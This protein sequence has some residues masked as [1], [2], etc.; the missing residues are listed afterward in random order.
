MNLSS[1]VTFDSTRAGS[2]YTEPR[3]LAVT[4]LR[5]SRTP[6]RFQNRTHKSS[7]RVLVPFSVPP[8]RQ[9]PSSLPSAATTDL[10]FFLEPSSTRA[11]TRAVAARGG[12]GGGSFLPSVR[13]AS[14][15]LARG[16]SRGF[17]RA[18]ISSGFAISIATR[19]ALSPCASRRSTRRAR[20]RRVKSRRAQTGS[21]P[22]PPRSTSRASPI[23]LERRTYRVLVR[24]RRE[25]NGAVNGAVAGHERRGEDRVQSLRAR[26]AVRG[27]GTNAAADGC[28]SDFFAAEAFSAASRARSDAL[29]WYP[30]RRRGTRALVPIGGRFESAFAARSPV[31]IPRTAASDVQIFSNSRDAISASRATRVFTS[32]SSDSSPVISPSLKV[33]TAVFAVG[34]ATARGGVR[35]ARPPRVACLARFVSHGVAGRKSSLA[36]RGRPEATRVIAE[37]H[38]AAVPDAIVAATRDRARRFASLA[39]GPVRGCA[40]RGLLYLQDG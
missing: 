22:S 24:V 37:T 9:A 28:A 32:A 29:G 26:F 13:L 11:P 23:R 5:H 36:Q 16:S 34:E 2:R 19:S 33:D 3:A 17:G 14:P 30:V 31:M 6:Q 27:V 7:A 18:V 21:S 12:G 15:R 40:R 10:C 1:R 4:T 25:T 35:H 39:P 8:T 38:P 20:R